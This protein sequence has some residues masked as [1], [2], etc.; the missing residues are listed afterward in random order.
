[1]TGN[2]SADLVPNFERVPRPSSPVVSEGAPEATPAPIKTRPRAIRKPT[3]TPTVQEPKRTTRRAKSA[4]E[5]ASSAGTIDEF[6]DDG[7][8]ECSSQFSVSDVE[9]LAPFAPTRG[10]EKS[11]LVGP[12]VGAKGLAR[13]VPDP[14][15]KPENQKKRRARESFEGVIIETKRPKVVKRVD[16]SKHTYDED[17]EIT[18]EMV[19]GIEGKVS[20]FLV[21]EAFSSLIFPCRRVLAALAGRSTVFRSGTS[22]RRSRRYVAWAACE[23]TTGVRSSGSIW[24]STPIQRW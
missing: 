14:S 11:I 18:A 8:F 23:A 21:S 17:T 4:T 15:K 7:S 16:L 9:P 6:S 2:L 20:L 19:P 13:K 12:P 24:A 3:A 22:I 10:K 1:M 5:E